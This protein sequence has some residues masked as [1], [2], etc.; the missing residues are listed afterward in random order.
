MIAEAARFG[1]EEQQDHVARTWLAEREPVRAAREVLAAAEGMSPLRRS[2]AVR[3]VEALGDDLF[4]P[5]ERWYQ[6]RAPA[7]RSRRR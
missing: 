2:V 5:N 7:R 6:L 1:D 4:I 3:L